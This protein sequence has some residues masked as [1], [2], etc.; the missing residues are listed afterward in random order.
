MLGLARSGQR[1]IIR[2]FITIFTLALS[3][4]VHSNDVRDEEK[5]E[6]IYVDMPPYTF[7]KPD[8]QAAGSLI[9][10]SRKA[11]LKAGQPHV[12]SYVP[13]AQLQQRSLSGDMGL[14]H[15]IGA[16]PVPKQKVLFG[17]RPLSYLHLQAYFIDAP[18]IR[19]ITDLKGHEVI[20]VRGYSYGYLRDYLNIPE[21]RVS[22]VVVESHQEALRAL[23][24]RPDRYLID[25]RKPLEQAVGLE[26]IE[27]LQSYSL[28]E[29]PIYWAAGQRY[30]ALLMKLEAQLN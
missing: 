1:L 2:L 27:A 18:A 23:K 26:S 15:L 16:F 11:L 22:A 8:G 20:L 5:L 17:T 4:I 28:S 7:R 25:Y 14:A 3:S 12:F 21:N 24:E 13:L 9:E 30:Q 6:V 10:L 29:I 19:A